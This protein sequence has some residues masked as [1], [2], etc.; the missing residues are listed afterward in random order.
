MIV[1]NQDDIKPIK[2]EYCVV[3]GCNP[4]YL[5]SGYLAL[6]NIIQQRKDDEFDI[7]VIYSHDIVVK[8]LS[9]LS[10]E[11]H[12]IRFIHIEF[13]RQ[14]L[15]LLYTVRKP[16]QYHSFCGKLDKRYYFIK[17]VY[18]WIFDKYKWV[19]SIDMNKLYLDVINYKTPPPENCHIVA[20]W[21]FRSDIPQPASHEDPY[22]ISD[23]NERLKTCEDKEK[24]MRNPVQGAFLIFN[25]ILIH[26]DKLV[27][28]IL[29]TDSRNALPNQID[30]QFSDEEFIGRLY[31]VKAYR[32]FR[33]IQPV[34]RG[35]LM[36]ILRTGRFRPL[37]YE[38][39]SKCDIL[40]PVMEMIP[41][42]LKLNK[43]YEEAET[44]HI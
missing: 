42:L 27:N 8:Y 24:F 5:P 20:N 13:F 7:W 31:P 12:L 10:D 4:L 29:F 21:S 34:D 15:S 43:Q 18:P 26:K 22:I 39:A 16:T 1:N 3:A 37:F 25:N 33:F 40:L 17:T 11:K 23:E 9:R 6:N 41:E 36:T 35:Q 30:I 38:Y 19:V 44:I 28:Q 2:S 32:I 14:W